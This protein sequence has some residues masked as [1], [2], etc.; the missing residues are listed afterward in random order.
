VIETGMD[1]FLEAL[2]DD[3]L[4]L[5]GPMYTTTVIEELLVLAA[6]VA[7]LVVLAV[8]GIRRLVRP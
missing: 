6:E 8:I 3:E 7:V 5:F 1:D 2:D 4:V